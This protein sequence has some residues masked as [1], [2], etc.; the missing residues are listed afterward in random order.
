MLSSGTCR[1]FCVAVGHES[2][3]LSVLS[4]LGTGGPLK[5]TGVAPEANRDAKWTF[6]AAGVP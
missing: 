4:R 2:P 5:C 1:V 6:E 3:L